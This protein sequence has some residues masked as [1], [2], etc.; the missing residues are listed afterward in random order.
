MVAILGTT[1]L[2]V[3][4]YYFVTFEKV[5]YYITLLE[6]KVLFCNG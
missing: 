5:I 2:I 4:V 3:T 6:R 1:W